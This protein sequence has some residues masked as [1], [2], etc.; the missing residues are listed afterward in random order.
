MRLGASWQADLSQ[1][2]AHIQDGGRV[3]R[4]VIAA[5]NELYFVD[6]VRAIGTKRPLGS[7]PV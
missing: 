2:I 3:T 5:A 6:H 4:T 1:T 7:C